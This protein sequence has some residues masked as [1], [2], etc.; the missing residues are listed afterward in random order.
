MSGSLCL[1]E[2]TDLPAPTVVTRSHTAKISGN[3][4]DMKMIDVP[5]EASLFSPAKSCSHSCGVSTVV[6][7]SRIR[8]RGLRYKAFM[9]STLCHGFFIQS[10]AEGLHHPAV[11]DVA[12]RVD[13]DP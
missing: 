13:H 12:L 3:L 7:S 11:R 6:G 2:A 9:I 10:E 8:I 4:W 5:S 1:A